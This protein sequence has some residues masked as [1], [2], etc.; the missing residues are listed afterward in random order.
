MKK[1]ILLCFF[2]LLFCLMACESSLDFNF[3]PTE[4]VVEV[5]D[6]E[7]K[8]LDGALVK[9]FDSQTAFETEKATGNAGL[10]IAKG[11]T[12]TEGQV[13]F[14]SND[15]LDAKKDHF[16]YVSFRNRERFVDLNNFKATYKLANEDN[17]K[18]G[19][20]YIQIQLQQAESAVSFFARELPENNFPL[21]IYLDGQLS[22]NIN[23]PS[24]SIPTNPSATNESGIQSFHLSE[25]KNNW[26]VVSKTGCIWLGQVTIGSTETHSPL[27]MNLCQAGSI[28]FWISDA[29]NDLLPISISLSPNDKLGDL[30]NSLT[31]P[32]SSCF[33]TNMLSVSRD[34]GEY[35]YF[36]NS[37]NGNCTWSG[38][39]ILGS[40]D[41][42]LIKLERCNENN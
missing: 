3:D 30:K 25:G 16:F 38:Q 23:Q 7:E 32:P 8:I 39:F 12:D 18:G 26:M 24:N 9:V 6:D 31:N 17:K 34:A 15:E 4:V 42:K 36:A 29:D 20:S 22:G 1:V 28:S 13:T 41:C 35:S 19:K 10:E 37:A 21:K 33:E 5:I 11:F 27:E 2:L 14:G 40:G